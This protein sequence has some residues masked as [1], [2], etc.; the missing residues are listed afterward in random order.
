M[1]DIIRLVS[2][3][4][5]KNRQILLFLIC[6]FHI[7]LSISTL[8]DDHDDDD[9]ALE[10]EWDR[11]WR[12][13]K[14]H[15]LGTFFCVAELWLWCFFYIFYLLSQRQSIF[16]QKR[17]QFIKNNTIY[18]EDLVRKR[19]KNR[20]I[21]S[22]GSSNYNIIVFSRHIHIVFNLHREQ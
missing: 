20:K 11:F 14:K 3:N 9:D 19:E 21:Y 17:Y 4:Y 22:G 8:D 13:I 10:W 12:I 2:K 6:T 16:D 18:N 15:I 1:G 5:H 7:S